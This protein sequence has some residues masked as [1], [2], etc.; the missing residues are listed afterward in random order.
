M[1]VASACPRSSAPLS[2]VDLFT[3]GIGPSSSDTVGPMRAAHTYAPLKLSAGVPVGVSCDLTFHKG[4]FLPE[5]ANAMRFV[6]LYAGRPRSET[7]AFLDT[8]RAAMMACIERNTMGAVKA[9]N[10]AYLAQQGDGT[11]IVSLDAV[12]KTVWQTGKDMRVKY[13]ETSLGGVAVN[14][15]E[16]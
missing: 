3:I 14:V 5:Q 6:A 7:I 12:I 16:C 4:T 1:T 2:V 10:A 13:R 15:V 9:I 11:H 8:V